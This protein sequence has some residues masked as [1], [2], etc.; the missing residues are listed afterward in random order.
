MAVRVNLLDVG[1]DFAAHRRSGGKEWIVR[2]RGAVSVQPHDHAGEM[3]VVGRGSAEG[4]VQHWWS[5][6]R[7]VRQV[8]QPTAP[9]V[10]AHEDVEL[11]VG[12]EAHHTAVMVGIFVPV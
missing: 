4:I 11:A 8:L 1:P 12:T 7:A 10:V 2:W 6:K 5:E 9:A 3:R